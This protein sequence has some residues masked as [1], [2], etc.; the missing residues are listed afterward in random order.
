MTDKNN[1]P[2]TR[3]SDSDEV[4]FVNEKAVYDFYLKDKV[5]N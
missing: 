2:S 5:N 1:T 4:E 3:H